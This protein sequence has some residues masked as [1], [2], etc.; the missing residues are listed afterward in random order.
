MENQEKS[1]KIRKNQEKNLLLL[2]DQ[3][4]VHKVLGLITYAI[5]SLIFV[6]I[7][8]YGNVGHRLQIGVPH[9]GRESRQ[10]RDEK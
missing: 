5:K 8:S 7:F 2:L 1:G 3:K 10:A 4:L 9:E 6:I